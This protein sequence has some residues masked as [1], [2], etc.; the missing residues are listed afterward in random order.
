MPSSQEIFQSKPPTDTKNFYFDFT[1]D[2]AI[3]ETIS[4]QVV[5]ATVW[6]GTD[7]NPSAVISGS[8]SAS[9]DVVT[10]KITAGVEGVTYRLLCTITTSGGQTLTRA[11][12]LVILAEATV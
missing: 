11:G 4:T 5:T 2:L 6:S 3:A 10:Q 8:A 7:A 1:G 9:G 12:Y